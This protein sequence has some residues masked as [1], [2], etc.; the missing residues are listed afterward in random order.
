MQL[1]VGMVIRMKVLVRILVTATV[2][3]SCIQFSEADYRTLT[4]SEMIQSA[5]LIAVVDI[6]TVENTETTTAAN[7]TY[8]QRAQAK[9]E[10]II[11]GSADKSITHIGDLKVKRCVPD[12]SLNAGKQL[13]FVSRTANG[14]YVS[15][16]SGMALIPIRGNK[17][18]WFADLSASFNQTE[19]PLSKAIDSIK[20]CL[21]PGVS[22]K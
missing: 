21:A 3:L 7:W 9:I 19:V 18:S 1:N 16:N 14:D 4:A 11:K 8:T 20:A 6:A 22:T 12:W 15:T 17:V 5:G 10:M 13:I 2:A